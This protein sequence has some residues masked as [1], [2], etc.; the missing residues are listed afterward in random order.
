[1][2]ASS[3]A[4]DAYTNSSFSA[5]YLLFLM[6]SWPGHFASLN[7]RVVQ[8]FDVRAPAE[9]ARVRVWIAWRLRRSHDFRASRK[10][11]SHRKSCWIERSSHWAEP[12]EGIESIHQRWMKESKVDKRH[13]E[14][15]FFGFYLDQKQHEKGEHS[16]V[17]IHRPWGT[18]AADI[19]RP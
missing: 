17:S 14:A 11:L 16:K 6:F 9:H 5:F 8:C 7:C 13:G 18:C 2:H 15:R 4:N 12:N 10:R 3:S 1:M 19:F